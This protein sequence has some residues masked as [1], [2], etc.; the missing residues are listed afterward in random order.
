MEKIDR[1]AFLLLTTNRGVKE[2]GVML[3][4]RSWRELSNVF[5]HQYGEHPSP[6]KT[7]YKRACKPHLRAPDTYTR[8][9]TIKGRGACGLSLIDQNHVG[10]FERVN[11]WRVNRLVLHNDLGETFYSVETPMTRS[12]ARSRYI[13][14]AD[15]PSQQKLV[16][17]L[18]EGM[19]VL[20]VLHGDTA[21]KTR[22]L[23]WEVELELEVYGYTFPRLLVGSAKSRPIPV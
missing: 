14:P 20:K 19:E 4:Y 8:V 11:R 10:G 1:M 3:G 7:F 23:N 21:I 16:V 5:K 6:W 15:Q 13:D 9:A 17:E 22:G 12:K 18:C 2:L